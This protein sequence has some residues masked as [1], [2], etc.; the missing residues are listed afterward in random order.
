[1]NYLKGIALFVAL[2]L[3]GGVMMIIAIPMWGNTR[4]NRMFFKSFSWAARK[5]VGLKFVV[6]HEERLYEHRPAVLV[7][8]HQTGLDLAIV[9][10]LCPTRSIVVAKRE[11]QFIPLFGWFFRAAGNL[12]INRSKAEDAKAMIN[13]VTRELKEKNLNL[14]IFP[15]G[16]RNRHRENDDLMLPFKKGAFHIASRTGF[17]I[18][19]VICSTLKG[20]SVWE[21]FDLRGGTVVMSILPPVSTEGLSLD[22]TDALRDTIREQMLTELKRIN[23]LAETYETQASSCCGGGCCS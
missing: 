16:T 1:M 17:P 14:V 15:E 5:I 20:K 4:L 13:R 9:G 11:I 19:P 7:S 18:V 8:N 12:L 10:S 22:Q 2:I 21:N 6:L 23:A 3:I